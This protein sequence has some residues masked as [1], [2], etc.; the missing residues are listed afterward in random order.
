[1]IMQILSPSGAKFTSQTPSQR[2]ADDPALPSGTQNQDQ[3]NPGVTSMFIELDAGTYN[4]QVLFNPQW[5][6]MS[7]SDFKSPSSVSIDSWT[8]DSHN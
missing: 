3:P 1:M 7:S 8:L 2:D 6:G 5:S 4:I